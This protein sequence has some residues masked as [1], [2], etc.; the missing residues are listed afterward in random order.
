MT[1]KKNKK[2]KDNKNT[3]LGLQQKL[4]VSSFNALG[5]Q[6]GVFSAAMLSYLADK[7]PA[8]VQETFNAMADRLAQLP[9]ENMKSILSSDEFLH[10]CINVME[11]AQNEHRE[12]KRRSYGIMLAN[13]AC[14]SEFHYDLFDHFL[15]LLGEMGDLHIALVMAL[16]KHGVKNNE[17][18]DMYGRPDGNKDKY[19]VSFKQLMKSCNELSPI[20]P[21]EIVVSALQKLA[22]YGI[23]KTIGNKYKSMM[24][25]NPVGL[26]YH[27]FY[28]ITPTGEKFVEFLKDS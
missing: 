15:S 12:N 13:M 20:P 24:G 7:R 2:H 19:W 17:D 16:A 6:G 3:A 26:W 14:A 5:P 4:F 8:N 11:K 28:S 1:T 23:I 21:H 25:T 27:S 18:M 22:E 10:L 9:K